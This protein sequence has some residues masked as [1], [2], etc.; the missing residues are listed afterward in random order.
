VLKD[1]VRKPLPL[2]VVWTIVR[3]MDTTHC[4]VLKLDFRNLR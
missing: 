4:E 3:R 2:I 1:Y